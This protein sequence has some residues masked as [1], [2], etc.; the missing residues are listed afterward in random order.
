MFDGIINWFKNLIGWSDSSGSGGSFSTSDGNSMGSGSGGG[1]RGEG[2]SVGPSQAERTTWIP[3]GSSS[4]GSSYSYVPEPAQ[5]AEVTPLRQVAETTSMSSP[6]QESS[7]A[8]SILENLTSEKEEEQSEDQSKVDPKFEENAPLSA[9]FQSM[10]GEDSGTVTTDTNQTYEDLFRSEG[11]NKEEDQNDWFGHLGD[12]LKNA[13]AA[14]GAAV[15]NPFTGGEDA[16]KFATAAND[17]A[18][19]ATSAFQEQG[20]DDG[21]ANTNN[22]TS[23]WMTGKRLKDYVAAGIPIDISDEEL[24]K[25]DDSEILN[26]QDLVYNNGFAAYTPDDMSSIKRAS[27]NV[28]DAIP[29]AFGD[30]R[31]AR[32]ANTAY[33]INLDGIEFD[34]KDFNRDDMSDWLQQV[35]NDWSNDPTYTLNSNPDVRI[36]LGSNPIAVDSEGYYDAVKNQDGT[37]DLYFKDGSAITFD[38]SGYNS[39][40]EEMVDTVNRI[41]D[42][43]M[44]TP[45]YATQRFALNDGQE[46]AYDQV[47]RLID[48]TTQGTDTAPGGGFKG[49]DGISYDFGFLN[50]NK[51]NAAFDHDMLTDENGLN[52]ED[53]VPRLVDVAASSAQYMLPLQYSVPISLMDASSAAQGINTQNMTADGKRYADTLTYFTPELAE[54]LE[55]AGVDPDDYEEAL[56]SARTQSTL[57]T[58]AMPVTEHLL[59]NIGGSVGQKGIGNVLKHSPAL[60]TAAG[61]I[62][63]GVEEI[64]S[65]IVEE[66][67]QNGFTNFFF[68]D[69]LT[70]RNGDVI[71][72]AS[73]QPLR[74]LSDS[75]LFGY[76]NDRGQTKMD[77]DRWNEFMDQAPDSFEAGASLGAAV[78]AAR[79]AMGLPGKLHKRRNDARN[80]SALEPGYE[81]SIGE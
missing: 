72:D 44:W 22:Y 54:Q 1:A 46:L 33:G 34:S 21:T 61:I 45:A 28:L 58:A 53:F 74:Q 75:T 71:R 29:R 78:E 55:Q 43:T 77:K 40:Y 60:R 52:F 2:E 3:S 11:W 50:F 70:D 62:G 38:G 30:L 68:E 14:G 64:P 79:A 20:I 4:S 67:A 16:N 81:W 10:D 63:E 31:N 15:S 66:G 23:N 42:P 6:M 25:I 12:A 59:G 69:N 48:D 76:T 35:N 36:S 17:Q 24:S 27:Q 56:R 47:R 73:G 49:D 41:N 26:K 19:Q 65:N 13:L 37:Y 5:V 7:S 39:A 32:E 51:P 18:A 80:Q 8:A 9:M 57:A